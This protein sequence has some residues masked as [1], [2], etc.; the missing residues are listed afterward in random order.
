MIQSFD[1]IW[2]A[3]EETPQEAENMKIRSKLMM[4]LTAH[5]EKN[6]MTQAQ[7][8][9][10]FGVTQ[11]RISDLVRGKI[12]VFSID[13]LV[14]MLASADLHITHIEIGGKALV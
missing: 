13:M 10:F 6:K 14:N 8:A 12:S 1:N 5:I 2:D 4:V 11:P 9:K 7:A 3:I